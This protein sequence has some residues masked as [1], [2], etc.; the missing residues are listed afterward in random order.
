MTHAF[1]S[2]LQDEKHGTEIDCKHAIPFLLGQVEQWSDLGNACIIKKHI[3]AP[4]ALVGQIEHALNVC[5][6][7]DVC[8]NCS[9]S[10]LASEGLCAFTRSANN[11]AAPSRAMRR[12]Q[13]APMPL[14]APVMSA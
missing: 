5:C 6:A 10:K 9:L 12:A 13:T 14:A 7:G 8:L 3:Q 4:P 11:N 1:G 2:A